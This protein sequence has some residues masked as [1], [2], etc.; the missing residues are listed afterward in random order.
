MA[1][2]NRGPYQYKELCRAEIGDNLWVVVSQR[3]DGKIIIATANVV[4]A[5]GRTKTVF[6][7]NPLILGSIEALGEMGN[8]LLD[9]HDKLSP[10]ATE[11]EQEVTSK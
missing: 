5:E 4:K 2:N 7:A 11:T 3:I 10:E 6:L 8:C 9:A 1:S